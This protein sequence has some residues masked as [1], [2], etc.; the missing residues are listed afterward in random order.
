MSIYCITTSN[1]CRFS[2]VPV[3]ST[4]KNGKP[5]ILFDGHRFNQHSNSKG[6]RGFFV[7]VKWGT[8]CRASIRTVNDE[9]IY[10]VSKYGRPVIQLGPYRYNR[11]SRCKGPRVQWLCCKWSSG[12]RASITTIEDCI[13]KVANIHHH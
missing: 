4:T 8:A 13:V 2:G 10:T 12:C 6:N 5:V 7:C 1:K 3:F 9:P 11:H